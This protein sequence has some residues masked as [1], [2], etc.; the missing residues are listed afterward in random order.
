MNVPSLTGLREH[1]DIAEW[2]ISDPVAVPYFDGLSLCFI[3]DGLGQED[4]EEA[5]STVAAFL[6]LGRSDRLDASP[7]VFANYRKMAEVIGEDELDCLV[8]SPQEVWPHVH[9]K[10]IFVKRRKCHEKALYVQIAAE[11]DWEP[12]HGLQIN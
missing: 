6:R 5:N 2:L 8:G 10:E 1:P 9:P 3:L 11:C 4:G 12:E 7:Y